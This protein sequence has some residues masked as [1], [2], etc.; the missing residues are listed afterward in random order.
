MIME[1]KKT[2]ILIFKTT[3][4]KLNDLGKRGETYDDIINRLIESEQG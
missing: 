3:R 2:T 1:E 4:K